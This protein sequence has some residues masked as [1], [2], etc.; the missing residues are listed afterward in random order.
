M[1]LSIIK[2]FIISTAKIHN[3]ELDDDFKHAFVSILR[4][5]VFNYSDNDIFELFLDN[6]FKNNDVFKRLKS[7]NIEAMTSKELLMTIINEFNIISLLNKIGNIDSNLAIIE[8]LYNYLDTKEEIGFTIYDLSNYLKEIL[9]ENYEIKFSSKSEDSNSVKIMTIHKSKGLEYSICYYA[10]LYNHF[11]IQETKDRFM[12]DNK[13]GIITPYFDEGIGETI[14]KYLI[15][16]N[17][18]KEEI[19]EKI[20]LLYVAF[21][22]AKEKMILVCDLNKDEFNTK[23]GNGVIDNITRLNYRSFLDIIVSTQRELKEYVVNKENIFITRDYEKIKNINYKDYIN[24]VDNKLNVKNSTMDNT[25]MEEKT[26]SKKQN[27]LL[28][29]EELDNMEYGTKVHYRFEIDD[30]ENPKFEEVKKFLSLYN[31]SNYINIY[32]EYEFIYEEDNNLYHGIIDLMFEYEKNIDIIDYKLS[33]IDEDAY[34]EQLNGYKKY[35]EKKT[36]K[37]VK[38]YLYSIMKNE[39]KEV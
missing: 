15:K 26:F 19:S 28:T 38:I 33:N 30:F 6:S 11:N 21:T 12:F 2:N 27:K 13:Y 18:I 24:K 36:N 20:R 39:L 25:L 4:S 35:I 3:N 17:L 14:Y 31:P 9:E 5:F 10:G 16:E 37:E 32:K 8:Y 29:K 22:R 23:D 34:I 1:I 7:I